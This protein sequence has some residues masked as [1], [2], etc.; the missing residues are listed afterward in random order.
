M[1]DSLANELAKYREGL[2]VVTKNNSAKFLSALLVT[3]AFTVPAF[4]QIETVVV[5]AEKKSEDIQ[6]VPIAVTSISGDELKQK[7][8]VTFKDLQY[9]VPNLTFA[10]SALGGGVVTLRGIGQAAGDPGISQYQN[11]VFSEETDL[12]SA[13]YYDLSSI[14]VLRGPQGTLYGRA[15]VGGLINVNS[16]MP[17]LDNFSA[18][19]DATYGEFNTIKGTGVL[20]I[21]ITDTLGVRFAG[22]YSGHD[23]FIKN[24]SPGAKDPD[25]QN[26][27]S[28]RASVRW[29]PTE[30]TTLD[31]V[32]N[33]TNEADTRDRIDAVECA[34]DPTGVLGCLPTSL[35]FQAPNALGNSIGVL[36]SSQ[37][38]AQV[39]Q[40]FGLSFTGQLGVNPLNGATF[41]PT[42]AAYS[43][44]QAAAIGGEAATLAGFG[45]ISPA[46]A[47]A[48]NN[49]LIAGYTSA[50]AKDIFA[51]LLGGLGAAGAKAGIFDLTQTLGKLGSGTSPTLLASVPNK[52]GV[53]NSPTITKYDE[54]SAHLSAHLHQKLSNWLNTDV[55]AGY[56]WGSYNSAGPYQYFPTDVYNDPA[57]ANSF[58][59]N[60]ANNPV[61]G[62][63]QYEQLTQLG[64]A[65]AARAAALL[66]N[67]FPGFGTSAAQ[68]FPLSSFQPGGLANPVLGAGIAKFV[69][70]NSAADLYT[71]HYREDSIEWRFNSNFEG[72]FNFTAGLFYYDRNTYNNPYRVQFN[73]GD[74]FALFLGANF[75][76]LFPTGTQPIVAIEPGYRQEAETRSS[77]KASFFDFTYDL[78]PDTLQFKGGLRWQED[79]DHLYDN[80]FQF[81]G[82]NSPAGACAAFG[83]S[84]VVQ[85]DPSAATIIAE[86]DGLLVRRQHPNRAD[87]HGSCKW[88]GGSGMDSETR[89]L[90]PVDTLCVL[91]A[92][93]E[94]WKCELG[95]RAS[96][97]FCAAHVQA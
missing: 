74:Y 7:E 13:D 65:G 9:N 52:L 61:N 97:R 25:G 95:H 24:I 58:V 38:L 60:S 62:L 48:I 85:A 83:G 22:Q 23:G 17:D 41:A 45:D 75:G 6:T 20:N 10:K 32:G 49:D 53:V 54:N 71:S 4:A 2:F 37:A 39:A 8:I 15:S 69:T 16:A 14:E 67:Y 55:V 87:T 18:S 3:T 68:Q 78:I 66:A 92:R 63:A 77:S 28:T 57:Y 40:G 93:I 50:S 19:G 12:A 81:S 36:D 91:R 26:I 33:Y 11:G 73:G 5:T 76:A 90:G 94:G 35:K 27:Y 80:H 44:L 31:V 96:R 70:G 29:Q 47:T 34:N 21:P 42:G 30:D 72:P 86:F 1:H 88:P 59:G 79:V 56:N 84:C 43:G 89:L 51:R 64:P 46:T 82:L